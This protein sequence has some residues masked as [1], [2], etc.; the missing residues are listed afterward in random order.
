[1]MLLIA[2][3]ALLG[4]AQA[5]VGSSGIVKPDGRNEQFSQAFADD[6]LFSGPAGIITK[7]GNNRQLTQAEASLSVPIPIRNA[8]APAP[9]L[10]GPS[11]ILYSDGRSVQFTQAQADNAA[12]VSATGIVNKDGKNIQFR[13]KRSPQARLPLVGPSGILHPDGTFTQFTTAQVANAVS[14]GPSGI[15]Q[16]NGV[17]TQHRLR[18][19]RSVN[20]HGDTVGPSAIVFANG[21]VVQFSKPGV[22]IA[23]RG[24]SGAV[25]SDGT[26]VQFNRK[27]RSTNEFGDLIAPSA[28][29]FAHGQVH[30]L[31]AAGVTIASRGEGGAVL[32]N[33]QNVQFVF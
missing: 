33:G 13:K 15:V 17:N 22:T 21:Q 6:I 25:L 19:R 24:D 11:G 27:K 14:F 3:C 26:N 23:A 8:P 31:P 29:V 4:T 7:S 28:I 5:Q 1:M 20:E 18:R 30:Q 12:V 2:V 32:S 10:V 16:S 9:P